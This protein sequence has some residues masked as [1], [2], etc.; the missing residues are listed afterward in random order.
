VVRHFREGFAIKFVQDLDAENLERTVIRSS[1]A[2]VQGKS[3]AEPSRPG[4]GAASQDEAVPGSAGASRAA[5]A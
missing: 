3:M 5:S 4:A 1:I 2:P